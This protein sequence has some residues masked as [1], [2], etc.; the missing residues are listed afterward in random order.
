MR[1]Q[2]FHCIWNWW[3]YMWSSGPSV[4]ETWTYWRESSTG[5]WGWWRDWSTSH[6]RKGWESWVCSAWRRR[7]SDLINVHKYLKGGCKE[8][9]TRL[10]SVVP[11]AWT[12]D[13]GHKLKHRRFP[14]SIRKYFF[15]VWVTEHWQRL[16]REAVESPSLEIFRR[17]LD[18]VL[19]NPLW[20][21]LLE[22]GFG[23]DDLPINQPCA[24]VLLWIHTKIS[25]QILM[26]HW[27][28]VI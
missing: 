6:V 19:D 23:P 5:P 25:S 11:C 15:T 12:R 26:I 4:W 22:Q 2:E 16:S 14:L 20:V 10:F 13:N 8:D 17:S 18:V 21:S 3:G 27:D 24:F 7:G 1:A 9:R 28:T